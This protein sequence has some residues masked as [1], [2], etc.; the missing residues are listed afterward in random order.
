MCC[1]GC[2]K[3]LKP[4]VGEMFRLASGAVRD[5]LESKLGTP[6]VARIDWKPTVETPIT[7]LETAQKLMSFVEDL[8]EDDDVQRV[9]TNANIA[10]DI[11][12]QL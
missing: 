7:D 10:E 3:F 2:K 12:A 1:S 9:I 5:A 4:H 11:L 6:N 8:N